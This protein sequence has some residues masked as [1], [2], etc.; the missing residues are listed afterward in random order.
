MRRSTTRVF[1]LVIGL[2]FH[3]VAG[4]FEPY[5]D[6]GGTIAAIAGPSY[7]IL[8]ADTRLSDGYI[9]RSR[10]IVRLFELEESS[11]ATERRNRV[12]FSSCGCW[13]D[14]LALVALLRNQALR[15]QWESRTPI[16]VDAMA[17]V[18]AQILYSRRLFPYFSFCVL[19]SL[20]K[21]GIH[22]SFNPH[23]VFNILNM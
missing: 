3:S 5:A 2:L 12:L 4:K 23:F 21:K 18:L 22:T 9:I 14:V 19:A 13:A 11:K 15:Y 10:D 20:D 1:C 16:A 6:N 7:C 17:H 8:A